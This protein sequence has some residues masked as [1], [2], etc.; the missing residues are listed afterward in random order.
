MIPKD[1]IQLNDEPQFGHLASIL[2]EWYISQ[3][4]AS[5][6]LPILITMTAQFQK[7][8]SILICRLPN[9]C[10]MTEIIGSGVENE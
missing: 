4:G 7:G 3:T 1:D 9:D 2:Q 8:A 10:F 5:I 6:P